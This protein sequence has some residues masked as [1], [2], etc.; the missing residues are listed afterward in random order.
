MDR[1]GLFY[2]SLALF[3]LCIN[4]IVTFTVIYLILDVLNLG[5][6]VE[7]HTAITDM[8]YWVDKGTRALY[9]SAI[10]LLSVGYGDITPFGWSRGIAILEAAIGYILPAVI[11]VQYLRLLPF[12]IEKWFK[13]K[14]SKDNKD[15]NWKNK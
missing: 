12:P 13:N 6:I 8:P 14:Y 5:Q 2:H 1:H 3:I 11:T 15:D 9:F 4:I 7:H 10:T